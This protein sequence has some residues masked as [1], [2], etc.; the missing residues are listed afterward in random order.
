[1]CDMKVLRLIRPIG[2]SFYSTGRL[3]SS[4]WLPNTSNTVPLDCSNV[5]VG[6]ATKR[7]FAEGF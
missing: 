4:R 5:N 3:M 2:W 6:N 1:M 7:S